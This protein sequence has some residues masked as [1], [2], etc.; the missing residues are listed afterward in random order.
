MG[1]RLSFTIETLTELSQYLE[2]EDC[3]DR[4]SVAVNEA[5]EILGNVQRLVMAAKAYEELLKG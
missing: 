3:S 4:F 1:D 5:I 2:M